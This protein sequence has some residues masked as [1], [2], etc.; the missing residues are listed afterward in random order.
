[1]GELNKPTITE[2]LSKCQICAGVPLPGRRYCARCEPVFRERLARKRS[3]R[4]TANLRGISGDRPAW[5]FPR[6]RS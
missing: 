2:A 1:M 6:G 4:A 3:R 5:L